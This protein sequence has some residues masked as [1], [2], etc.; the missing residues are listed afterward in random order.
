M[1]RKTLLE[2][3]LLEHI[4]VEGAQFIATGDGVDL[5]RIDTW[6]AAQSF[7]LDSDTNRQ[8]GTVFAQNQNLFDQ[9]ITN[10]ANK[11]YFYTTEDTN[12]VIHAALYNHN[13]TD[14][15]T[16]SSGQQYR[17]RN[18]SF[19]GLP[20]RAI[21][22][23]LLTADTLEWLPDITVTPVQTNNVEETPNIADVEITGEVADDETPIDNNTAP[24][25]T[26]NDGDAINTN[27]TPNPE[28]NV[29]N[30]NATSSAD[31]KIKVVNG[32]GIVVGVRRKEYP[33]G[34]LVIPE[35]TEN[36]IPI[37]T[38]D[39]FAFYKIVLRVRLECPYIKEIKNFA[40]YRSDIA[41]IN[42]DRRKCK[43]YI[44]SF[45]RN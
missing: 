32:E 13:A 26:T 12:R 44:N 31:L 41:Y 27:T 43:T 39:S 40:F 3:F 30:N 37:T 8:A 7:V 11:I 22:D 14:L 45:T 16:L 17:V 35:Y 6:A 29:A 5:F 38:I 15:I 33:N 9:H 20:G 1:K 25:D 2:A 24:E 34:V 4:T 19:E 18:Y 42:W 28:N 10:G 23:E 21:P 36:G